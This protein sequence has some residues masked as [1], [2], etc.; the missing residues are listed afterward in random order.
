MNYD[1]IEFDSVEH[2]RKYW[3]NKCDEAQQHL[4]T[5]RDK[6]RNALDRCIAAQCIEQDRGKWVILYGSDYVM[7]REAIEAD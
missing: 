4:T 6:V 7:M 1:T 2:E 3:M 5:L